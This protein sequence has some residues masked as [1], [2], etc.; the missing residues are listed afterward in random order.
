[1]TLTLLSKHLK[2]QHYRNLGSGWAWLIQQG[3]VLKITTT[4]NQDNPLMD[5]V[6]KNEQ[7]IPL[8]CID[9]W[10]HAYYLKHQNMRANYIDAFFNVI[11]WTAV[12]DRLS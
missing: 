11:N 10:E 6:S 12:A 4:A 3:D 7:G 1:V 5:V 9:V 8:L 2:R